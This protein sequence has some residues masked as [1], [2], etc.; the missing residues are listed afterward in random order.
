MPPKLPHQKRVMIRAALESGIPQ[1]KVAELVGVGRTTVQSVW[2]DPDLSPDNVAKLK[3]ILPAR[4]YKLAHR[5]IENVSDEKLK[6]MDGYRLTLTS[7][8][9]VDAARLS[10][11]L[12]TKTIQIRSSAIHLQGDIRDLQNR[13][14]KLLATLGGTLNDLHDVP[15]ITGAKP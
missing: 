4:F 13:K 1:R 8:I 11:G 5:A 15:P 12:P 9:A 14:E 6:K 2:A 3:D 10:E 7:K